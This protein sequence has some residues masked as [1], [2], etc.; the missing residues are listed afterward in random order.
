MGEKLDEC[1]KIL[2]EMDSLKDWSNLILKIRGAH[3]NDEPEVQ[4]FLGQT[5]LTELFAN[6]KF[7]GNDFLKD[8]AK[9]ILEHE[10]LNWTEVDDNGWYTPIS[11]MRKAQEGESYECDLCGGK[12]KKRMSDKSEN[13]LM[14]LAEEIMNEVGDGD[15]DEV[16]KK[17]WDFGR[18]DETRHLFLEDEEKK[19]IEHYE[20]QLGNDG[21]VTRKLVETIIIA[22]VGKR[23]KRRRKGRKNRKY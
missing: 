7:R 9:D 19:V 3:P 10:D 1:K 14:V 15:D 13:N 4:D 6:S 5:G 12:F 2:R 16:L 21:K 17:M 18:P 22:E 8:C 23:R 11:F 20:L